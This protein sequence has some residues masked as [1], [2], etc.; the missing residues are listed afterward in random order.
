MAETY[1]SGGLALPVYSDMA[2]ARTHKEIVAAAQTDASTFFRRI[3]IDICGDDSVSDDIEDFNVESLLDTADTGFRRM[4]AF[5]GANVVEHEWALYRPSD[6]NKRNYMDF[7]E[8]SKTYKFIP[9]G[10]LLIAEV[11]RI[12]N[13]ETVS[14]HSTTGSDLEAAESIYRQQTHTGGYYMG[15][16][17]PRQFV[18]SPDATNPLDEQ[19]TLVDIDI[20]LSKKR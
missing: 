11:E 4:A 19:L 17:D 14:R 2:V 16:M 1:T 13:A 15:D 9:E 8:W 7:H 6:F 12:G 10:T 3:S 20:F 18:K 5:C